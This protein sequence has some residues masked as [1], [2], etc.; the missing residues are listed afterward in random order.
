[1]RYRSVT[2]RSRLADP[3]DDVDGVA[4]RREPAL[5]LRPAEH[6][7]AHRRVHH[8][9]DR[10]LRGRHRRAGAVAARS[11]G[12]PADRR[13]RAAPASRFDRSRSQS[14]SVCRWG[15]LSGGGGGTNSRGGGGA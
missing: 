10:S 1:M 13:S 9:A 4:V 8:A 14:A 5:P 11:A 7:P 3:G 6:R 2:R 15:G 12:R